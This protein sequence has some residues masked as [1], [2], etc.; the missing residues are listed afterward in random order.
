LG[1]N[2]RGGEVRTGCCV[3]V[4][5]PTDVGEVCPALAGVKRIG[6]VEEADGANEDD[7]AAVLE[8]LA[9][10]EPE[11]ENGLVVARFTAPCGW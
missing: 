11:K 4:A 5:L 8:P 1:V 3:P 2:A 9:E 6:V 10:E 7:D